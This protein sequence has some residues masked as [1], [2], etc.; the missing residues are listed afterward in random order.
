[1]R[2]TLA[3]VG[4]TAVGAVPSWLGGA[5]APAPPAALAF[6]SFA[7]L[8]ADVF[9]ADADGGN[10]RPLLPHPA[11]DYDASFSPDGRW[12]VFTSERNGAA[13][14]YRVH[15][16]GTGLERL[17]D[18][19]A[20][21]DQGALSPDGH[22]LAFVSSRSGQADVWLLDVRTHTLRNLTDHP[23]G[24]FR[25]AWSP[26]GVWIAFS[27]DRDSP[28][29]RSGF[30]I[31][32]SADVY[33]VRADGSGLRR[34]TRGGAFVGSPA[35]SPDGARL[36]VY[37]ATNEEVNNLARVR[38]IRATTQIAAV[39]LATGERRVLTAGPGEK[40]S[41][42]W[43]PDGRIG[44][45]SGGPEGGVEFVGPAGGARAGARGEM[46]APAWSPDGRH[47]VFHRD[48]ESGW[49]PHRAWPSR[50]PRYALVR[51]G[52]FP[53]YAPAG[54]RFVLNDGTAGIV[55]NRILLADA[56]GRHR[57]V[58]FADSTR[59]A[60]APVW[61]PRGDRIAFAVGRFFP[62]QLGPAAASIAV[63]GA[64]GAGLTLLTDTAGNA[65]FPSWSPDGR[66]IVYRAATSK[67]SALMVVD[68]ESRAVRALTDGSA[69][70]NSP[71]WWPRGDRIAFTAKRGADP[72]YDLYTVRPDGTG[73][74]RLTR[75]PG[76]DSHPAWSPDGAWIAF[77]SARGGF[78]DE[79]PLH[80]FNSQ[81][82]GDIYVMRADGSDVR[83][84]T[85]NQFEDGTPVWI[86]NARDQRNRD[87]RGRAP[88][89][90]E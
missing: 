14:I 6:A 62:G 16:D 2:L 90:R 23:G 75:A 46:R 43:L 33:I 79:A 67:G 60:L 70:D 58:L 1:V 53:S 86:P 13:D 56:D 31:R 88:R 27:S 7:P 76:N 39:D 26:D 63:I 51:T 55:H 44:Y 87:V 41:P 36:A 66:E 74:T 73:L 49:P 89:G 71:A 18:H 10:A 11:L 81:P 50:D 45:V 83:M 29:P 80:P 22:T 85:D 68:V 78:K 15:P 42:R 12:V 84:L 8:N 20:F 61:S 38:R 35:W 48:V 34:V 19:R 69:N 30:T 72:D 21:D 47:M 3:L 82:Y 65:G 54:D 37:E 64:D 4:L 5:V 40:W 25:P 32:H 77:T 9:V 17:T 59:S 24:D 28:K 52:I 57:A